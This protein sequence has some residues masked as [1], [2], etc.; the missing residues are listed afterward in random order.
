VAIKTISLSKAKSLTTIDP[1]YEGIEL[2]EQQLS[3]REEFIDAIGHAWLGI[4]KRY[5]LIGRYLIQAKGKLDHGE[6]DQMI[7]RDLPFS[8]SIAYRI[9]AA[10]DAVTTGK[11]AEHEIP[12]NYSLVYELSLLDEEGLRLAR[13]KN[14]IR[15]DVKRQEIIAFRKGLRGGIDREALIKRRRQLLAQQETLRRQLEEIEGQLGPLDDPYDSQ[16]NDAILEGEAIE[17]SG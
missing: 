12:S 8:R 2:T 7:D 6:Y 3:T 1:R 14:L 13:E 9:R 15:P 10:T 17:V 5:L 11:L 16:D 4:E